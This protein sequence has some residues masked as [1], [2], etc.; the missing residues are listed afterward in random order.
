[1]AQ[2]EHGTPPDYGVSVHPQAAATTD[3]G[4]GVR[5]LKQTRSVEKIPES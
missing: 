1:V 2:D 3:Q 5:V 4:T